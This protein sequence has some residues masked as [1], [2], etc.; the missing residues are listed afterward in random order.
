[1]LAIPWYFTG[2]AGKASLF[3]A[4]YAVTTFFSLFW[5]LYAGTL[6]DRFPRKNI[7]IWVSLVCGLILL[8]SAFTAYHN[9]KLLLFLAGLVFVTTMFNYNIHYGALYAFGQELSTPSQYGK[10]SSYLEIQNQATSVLSGTFAAL[11][12][13][14]V[15]EGE[16]LNIAGFNIVMPF[17]FRQW[18]M[19]DIFLLNGITYLLAILV[20]S[21]IRYRPG[22]R[23]KA[24]TESMFSRI[25]E[26]WL[27]LKKNPALFA[28]GNYSYSIFVVLMV[29][30]F[31][32]L[33]L[34][35]NQQLQ[36][37]SDVFASAEI[38]YSLGAMLAGIF[39]RRLFGGANT[40]NSIIILMIMTTIGFYVVAF[41]QVVGIYYFFSFLIGITNAGARV[42]RTTF[43]FTHV[44]ND[45]IGR[46]NG[47]F[48]VI[49]I[50]L[51][52]FFLL[53]FS[54]AWFSTGNNI[55]WAY[56]ICGTFVLLSGAALLKNRKQLDSLYIHDS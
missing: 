9:D 25:R 7:F 8:G 46:T 22:E 38:F 47:V 48:N 30:V 11:L 13:T 29:Q 15:A 23:L 39:V 55:I 21:L 28:F 44:S 51:R 34:Y 20:V 14:G 6:I 53:I 42:L 35:V 1:M 49:N 24:E 52:S 37:G 17:S 10:I 16:S 41:T 50:L 12:L 18:Q 36:R 56:V 27:Y 45:I 19:A 2:V 33:P 26:G 5:N 32:L 3:G 40:V 31:L 43:I 4:I 54:L